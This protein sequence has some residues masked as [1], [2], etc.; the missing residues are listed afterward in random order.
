MKEIRNK[1]FTKKCI[2][3]CK[4]YKTVIDLQFW[5]SLRDQSKNHIVIKG[6]LESIEKEIKKIQD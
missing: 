6:E 2:N 1:C 3:Q 4:L 5:K